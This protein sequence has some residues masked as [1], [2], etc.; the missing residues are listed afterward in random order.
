MPG[1]ATR[2]RPAR[3][4][5][6]GA[7]A[8]CCA[9]WALAPAG[10]SAAGAPIVLKTWAS[11]VFSS[12]ARLEARLNPN[13]PFTTYHFEYIA[14]AAYEAN[15]A[16]AK[17]GFAGAARVPA[18]SEANAGSGESAVLVGQQASGLAPDT[19]Y[20]Y[21]IVA[22]NSSTTTG[23]TFALRTQVIP[24][25]ADAC[26]N[27]TARAQ[28]GARNSGVPDCRSWEMVSPIDKN[29]GQVAAPGQIAGGGVLQAAAQGGAVTYGSE[30]SF[31]SGSGAP[32]ASQYLAT[33]TGGGWSNEDLSLPIFSGSFHEAGEGVPYRVFSADLARAILLNGD[34]CRGEGSECAVANPPL[35]GTDAPAGYQDYYLAEGAA[36]TALLSSTNAGFLSLEPKDFEL[37]LA[38]S[39]TDLK[40]PVVQ[41]CAAL[42]SNATEVHEGEGCVAAE[43][44]LYLWS[45]SV[46]SLINLLPAQS[47]GTPG[48]SLA[49]QSGAVSEDGSRVYFTEAEDGALYLREGAQTKLLPETTGGGA[50]FQAASTD[51]QVAFFLKAGHL[52]RYSAAGAGQSTDLTPAGEVK[53]VLGASSNGT[54]V[55]FQD[56]AGLKKWSSGTTTTVAPDADAA[57]EGAWP[58]ATGASRVSP[59]G[60]KLLF[61]STE[62]LT[63]YDNT[64]LDTGE[65]DAEVFLYDGSTLTCAS[66]NP[67]LGRPV[68]PSSIPGAIANGEGK[69][70]TQTYKPRALSANGRRVFFDSK[71][72]LAPADTDNAPDAYQWEASGEGD[73]AR[74]GGCVSLISDG[75]SAGGAQFVDASAD[76]SD[77]FFLTSGSLVKADPGATDLYD[78][79]VGGGFAEAPPPITCEGDSCQPLPSPPVDPTLTTLLAGPGNPGVRYPGEKKC[80]KGEVKKKGKC[81]KKGGAKKKSRGKRGRTR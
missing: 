49:A 17:E 21:R 77:A 10:A 16:A 15:L 53:G 54:V 23:T 14:E 11:E 35:P 38:G 40:H 45:G 20:R 75:R 30:A 39:S 18:S 61:T 70:V 41:T 29:G 26:A 59:D 80:P 81:I 63:G 48:A 69:A 28:S 71:D 78:A 51:G 6:G 12:S 44:N 5:G 2:R 55:Y 13:G 79:K 34:R 42:T 3:W 57:E 33:R 4:L 50:S 25:G 60:S 43:T 9:L 32:P 62:Q 37:R 67:T 65:A 47:T 64:D 27:A 72:S 31:A 1:R 36:F 68:G 52:Y 24:T 22:K 66:C 58:P 19:F 73:C 76:G 7:I 8:L 74:T 56:E 46:L